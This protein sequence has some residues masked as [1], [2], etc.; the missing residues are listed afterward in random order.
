[1][2]ATTDGQQVGN[3]DNLQINPTIDELAQARKEVELLKAAVRRFF[4]VTFAAQ[5]NSIS[6]SI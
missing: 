3:D 4:I 1:M 5:G 6:G 2:A